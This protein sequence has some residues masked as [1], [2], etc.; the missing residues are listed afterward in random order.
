MVDVPLISYRTLLENVQTGGLSVE[1]GLEQLRH[2]NTD[3]LGFARVDRHRLLRTGFAEVVYGEGKTAQQ[4]IAIMQSI[5]ESEPPA[6]LA[7]RVSSPTAELVR[8]A[9]P[10]AEYFARARLLRWTLHPTEPHGRIAVVCAGT[11]DLPVAEEA[12]Y[13]AEAMGNGVQLTVDVGV[14]GLPRLLD[15]LDALKEARVL[16][17][18]AGM[19]GAL[20]SVLAGLI[21]KPIV[22]V[23]TSVGYGAS[24]GGVA[25]L[26]TMLNSC[27]TGVAVV[28]IDN[29]FGAG[30]LAALINRKD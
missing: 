11:T 22:A 14:A 3:A 27:A 26:L 19:E 28:N 18:V 7:S 17:V 29:G 5:A 10:E 30:C 16:I 12:F 23:P 24:F 8:E 2:I 13:A 20:P 9:I 15:Q 1:Q 21:G 4:I 25:A 6:V